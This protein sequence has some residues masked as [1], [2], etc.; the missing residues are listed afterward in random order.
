M[1]NR[2]ALWLHYIYD[3]IHKCQPHTYSRTFSVYTYRHSHTWYGAIMRDSRSRASIQSIANIHERK[4][5]LSHSHFPM[6]FPFI[7][8]VHAKKG[9]GQYRER[10]QCAKATRGVLY[11][12]IRIYESIYMCGKC[13]NDVIQLFPPHESSAR[14]CWRQQGK[15]CASR[16]MR[17]LFTPL[18][19]CV[20]VCWLPGKSMYIKVLEC[21]YISLTI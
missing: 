6:N 5:N 14:F 8:T 3:T 1:K 4:C 17:L 16:T 11:L 21:D 12:Y 10:H 20:C 13:A 2:T 18:R 15:S 9:R 7:N 19:L